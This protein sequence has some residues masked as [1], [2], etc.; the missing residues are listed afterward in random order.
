MCFTYTIDRI[1]DDILLNDELLERLQAS[2][3]MGSSSNN[4]PEVDIIDD[5]CGNV[6]ISADGYISQRYSTG[7]DSTGFSKPL[8]GGHCS[9]SFRINEHIFRVDRTDVDVTVNYLIDRVTPTF[10]SCP[11][12]VPAVDYICR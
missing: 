1:D 7:Q 10:I 8:G 5:M 4:I 6:Y 9:V 3:V 12:P 11:I 2:N